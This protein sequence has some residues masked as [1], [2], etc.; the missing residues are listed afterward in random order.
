MRA[1]FR[2][3][4]RRPPRT[5]GTITLSGPAKRITIR[6]DRFGVPHIDASGDADAWYGV[7]FCVGQDRTFQLEMLLRAM[8]GTLS[9]LVG[10]DGLA[11]DRFSRRVGFLRAAERRLAVIDSDVRALLAAYAAGVNAG[12]RR[13]RRRRAHEFTLL[14][15]RPTPWREVDVV[16][17]IAV[18]GNALG[19]PWDAEL[20]RLRIAQADGTDAVAALEGSYPPEHPVASPPGAPAGVAADRLAH[21]LAAFRSLVPGGAGSNNWA[22]AAARTATGRPLLANDTHLPAVLPASWYLAHLRTPAWEVAGGAFVGGPVIA[23]GHNGVCAWGTTLAFV[24]N[25]D[26]FVEEVGPDGSSVREGEG[27]VPCEVRSETI[28]VRRGAPVVEEVLETPR[29]PVI[30]P[31]VGDDPMALSLRAAWLDPLPVRGLIDLPKVRSFAEFR[32][33]FAQWPAPSFNMAYADRSGV[34]GWQL[35]GTAPRR[36]QG[37]GTFPQPGWEPGA[38]WRDGFVPFDELP[39]VADPPD[40]FVASANAKPASDADGPYLG[41]EWVEGYRMA[42]VVEAL[43]ARDDWTVASVAELQLDVESLPWRQLREILLETPP[44]DEDAAL[45]LELLRG[46]DGRVAADS[47]A[48]AVFELLVAELLDRVVAAKAP[49]SARWARGAGPDPLRAETEFVLRRLSHL[50]RLLSE[51]PAGWFDRTWPQETADALG[52]AVRR[53]RA[54]HGPD[55]SAWAWG[56]VRPLTLQHALGVRPSLARVFNIW[57]LPCGGDIATL[58]QAATPPFD[59]FGSPSWVAVLRMCVDVG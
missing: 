54:I 11:V 50:Q 48:A 22:L 56:R 41:A 23:A 45:G 5:R 34:I 2:L 6:R 53:L 30:G 13:G 51:Q 38:G 7:G 27:F 4:G 8:R 20:A 47:P 15:A 36:P 46:W 21:D 29:G 16:G 35:V 25:A 10:A 39:W 55:P 31:A 52:T 44:I 19:S 18:M 49:A 42:R 37:G 28:E 33:A 58:A 17:V 3:L 9:E 1:V 43:R 59:P 14:R 12:A 24:D 32:T 40:G 26:L 57:P